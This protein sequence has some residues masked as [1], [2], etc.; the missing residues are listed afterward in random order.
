MPQVARPHK[1]LIRFTDDE[2]ALLRERAR[3][4]GRPLARYVRETSLG[5]VP[6]VPREAADA[7]LIRQLG[8]IGNNLTQLAREANGA[9]EFPAEQK[10]EAALA[11][12]L[13][14]LDRL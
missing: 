12:L 9:R 3:A 13:S 4:A 5:V 8:R 1:R 2:L 7:E 6:Q 14:A 11:A 10:I